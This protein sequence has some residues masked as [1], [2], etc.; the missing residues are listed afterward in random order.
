M[1][2]YALLLELARGKYHVSGPSTCAEA[3][4]ALRVVTFAPGVPASG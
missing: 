3:A 2:F 4:L 1:L